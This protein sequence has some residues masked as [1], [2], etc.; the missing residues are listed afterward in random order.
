MIKTRK[1]INNKISFYFQ[2]NTIDLIDDFSQNTIEWHFNSNTINGYRFINNNIGQYTKNNIFPSEFVGNNTSSVFNY[3]VFKTSNSLDSENA[4][5]VRYCQFGPYVQ[6]NN[7]YNA[8]ASNNSI[9]NLR[10]Q[11]NLQGSISEY[12]NIQVPVNAINEIN[13]NKNKDNKIILTD[14][15]TLIDKPSYNKINHGTSDTTFTLTPNTFH[16]WDTVSNLSITLGEETLGVANEYMFQFTSGSK[17]TTLILPDSIKF[18][19]DFTVEVNK[20]YQ[21]SILNGLGTVMSW[22]D[23]ELQNGGISGGSGN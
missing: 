4:N 3:N 16:V 1:F 21:I 7:F 14:I 2:N 10:V 12:N 19:S 18:N 8:N 23:R 20:I 22:I 11:C 9:Q 6:Y 15:T 13:I 17:P 5:S